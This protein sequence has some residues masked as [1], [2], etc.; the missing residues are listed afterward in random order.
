L[1][2]QEDVRGAH[3]C[4]NNDRELL[5]LQLEVEGLLRSTL[6]GLSAPSVSLVPLDAEVLRRS[7]PVHEQADELMT[8]ILALDG[9]IRASCDSAKGLVSTAARENHLKS[10]KKQI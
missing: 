3:L 4:I 9:V 8:T 1:R 5:G 6:K 2:N 10:I 7:C